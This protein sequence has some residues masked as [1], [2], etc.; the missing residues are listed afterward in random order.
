MKNDYF[1]KAFE[2]DLR[3]SM[4][5]NS[6]APWFRLATLIAGVRDEYRADF[7][8]CVYLAVLVDQTIATYDLGKRPTLEARERERRRD[9][10]W[11]IGHDSESYPKCGPVGVA[12]AYERP[13]VIFVESVQ[14]GIHS[15]GT[16]KDHLIEDFG[17]LLPH[18]QAFI[19]R[20]GSSA[21]VGH[22]FL[23]IYNDSDV[24]ATCRTA[25]RS[26]EGLIKW[27]VFSALEAHRPVVCP[28]LWL[29]PENKA[30]PSPAP[31]GSPAAGSPSGEA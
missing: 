1:P 3:T 17:V 27:S 30:E 8:A 31:Y 12:R 4:A 5:Q 28:E 7:V 2:D 14:L 22:V 13:H 11:N 29:S 16:L 9:Q 21:G 15:P 6:D 24:R 20:A 26:P 25:K 19:R 10:S 23:R 18:A